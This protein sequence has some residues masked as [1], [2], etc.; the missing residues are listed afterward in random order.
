MNMLLTT[1]ELTESFD[2]IEKLI[3]EHGSDSHAQAFVNI[4]FMCNVRKHLKTVL[5]PER[6][7]DSYLKSIDKN[8]Y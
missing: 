1:M 3:I 5:T 7:R 8:K 2:T 4:K 6:I